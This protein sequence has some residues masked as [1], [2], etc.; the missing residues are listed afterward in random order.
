MSRTNSEEGFLMI[1]KVLAVSMKDFS[2][3][4]LSYESRI[5][6]IV[7]TGCSYQLSDK[8]V[9]VFILFVQVKEDILILPWWLQVRLAGN[10]YGEIVI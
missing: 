10:I 2:I 3:A 6:S 7:K 9:F 4:G 1:L 5:C 8:V